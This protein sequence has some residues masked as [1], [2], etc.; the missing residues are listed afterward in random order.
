MTK[1]TIEMF[2]DAVVRLDRVPIDGRRV[3]FT[4][5]SE[6]L[7]QLTERLKV[8]SVEALSAT[9]TAK[10]LRGGL[11]V[12]GQVS[13]AITQACVVTLDPVTQRIDETVD[14]VFLPASQKPKE[15]EPGT[16]TFVDLEGDDPPDYIEGNEV[17]L[18]ELVIETVALAVDPY[19]RAEGVSVED[20]IETDAPAEESP[21]AK[22]KQLKSK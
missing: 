3:E 4:A 18:T 21:F 16:E 20:V 13:A 19:P 17:D 22:L 5:D 8:Q 6:A 9:L 14:R 1:T 15:P 2:P 7:A 12:V 10:R 11:Q